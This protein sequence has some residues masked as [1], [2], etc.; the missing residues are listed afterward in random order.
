MR[1][2]TLGLFPFFFLFSLLF[3]PLSSFAD[4]KCGVATTNITPP[5]GT[6]SAG[7]QKRMGEGMEGVH[8][9]CLA[10]ALFVDNGEQSF[11]FISVDHLGFDSSMVEEVRSSIQQ[12]PGCQNCQ[13]ILCSTHTHSGGGAYLNIPGFGEAIAGV[14]DSKARQLYI[15][16]AIEATRMAVDNRR[17]ARFGMGMINVEGLNVYRGSYPKAAEP[18]Q[19]LTV[20]KVVDGDDHPFAI[21]YNFPIHPTVLPYQNCQFSADFIASSRR[22]LQEEY[23]ENCCTLFFNGAQG[24]VNPRIHPFIDLSTSFAEAERIGKDM[25][26]AII[27]VCDTIQPKDFVS[28]KHL[29]FPYSF[30]VKPTVFGT[31]PPMNMYHTELNLLVFDSDHV[32][33]CVPGEL[34]CVYDFRLQEYAKAIGFENLSIFGLCNDAHGYILLPEAW[35]IPSTESATSFGGRDYGDRVLCMLKDLLGKAVRPPLQMSR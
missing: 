5:I 23:G 20:W 27:E 4:L 15:D 30:Q 17:T 28:I 25:A 12:L 10:T 14:F 35:E 16:G 22:V 13:L 29:R 19:S 3:Y 31:C 7:Y 6:P 11:A 32:F 24:D 34:S 8:D 1:R 21:L 9:P 18:R 2:K 26:A 33:A